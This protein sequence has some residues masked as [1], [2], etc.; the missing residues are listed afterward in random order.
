LQI[1]NVTF[2]IYS[3]RVVDSYHSDTEMDQIL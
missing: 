1:N 3:K 2:E